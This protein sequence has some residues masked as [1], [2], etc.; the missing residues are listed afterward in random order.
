[1][2]AGVSDINFFCNGSGEIDLP[3]EGKVGEYSEFS[4]DN[5]RGRAG[6]MTNGLGEGKDLLQGG[7]QHPR[8]SGDANGVSKPDIQDVAS[9]SSSSQQS[10]GSQNE[11]PEPG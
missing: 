5:G 11:P 8:Q 7:Q 1:M 3:Q 2:R 4:P 9:P 10:R 6:R